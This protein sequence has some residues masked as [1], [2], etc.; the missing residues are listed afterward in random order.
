M[1]NIFEFFQVIDRIYEINIF[2]LAILINGHIYK[3]H[4]IQ[5]NMQEIFSDFWHSAN[6]IMSEG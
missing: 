2:V 4:Y 1:P 3:V 6:D 5:C